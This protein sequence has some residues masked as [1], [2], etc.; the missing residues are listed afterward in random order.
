[1]KATITLTNPQQANQPH[2]TNHSIWLEN[3]ATDTIAAFKQ[4]LHP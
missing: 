4:L 1:M 2:I 3:L